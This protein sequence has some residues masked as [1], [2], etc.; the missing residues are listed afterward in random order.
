MMRTGANGIPLPGAMHQSCAESSPQA[1]TRSSLGRRVV[2]WGS[3]KWKRD[4]NAALAATL[5]A[6]YCKLV[7]VLGLAIPVTEAVAQASPTSGFHEAFQLYLYHGSLLFLLFTYA[8]LL[9][10]EPYQSSPSSP[11]ATPFGVGSVIF[12]GLEFGQYFEFKREC[13]SVFMAINPLSRIVFISVQMVFIFANNKIM[14][15]RKYQVVVRFGLMHMIATNMCEWLKA[16]VQETKH[17]ILHSLN[18]NLHTEQ[19]SSRSFC[20][21][22]YIMATVLEDASPFLFPFIV[23]YSLLCAVILAVM[24]SDCG[25]PAEESGVNVIIRRRA[26]YRLSVDCASSYRGIFAGVLVLVLT[27]TS[28]LTSLALSRR[29]DLLPSADLLTRAWEVALYA[30]SAA[31]AVACIARVRSLRFQSGR[32]LELEHILLLVTQAGVLLYCLFQGLGTWLLLGIQLSLL[33]AL[34]VP[35]TAALQSACLSLALLDAWRRRCS[36]PSQLRRKPGRQVVS[37]LL[38]ANV[39]LW[40]LNRLKN[41]RAELQPA[42]MEFY[43]VWAWTLITRLCMPLVLCYRFHSTVCLYE[44]WKHAYKP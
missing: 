39:A 41:S 34:L 29:P 6:F 8:T 32:R 22:T 3:H 16:L 31:A 24:W 37:F 28:L 20:R 5:S 17:D 36:S 2:R 10:E 15:L 12:S 23:E 1:S 33:P 25:P 44:V 4:G 9:R 43:G 27:I 19:A 14:V 13:S 38:V 40:A 30:A 11:E 35:V 21:N 42:L 18:E 26:G 7:V